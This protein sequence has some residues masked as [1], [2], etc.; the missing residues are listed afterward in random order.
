MCICIFSQ[1]EPRTNMYYK[2]TVF[3][4][5]NSSI[6]VEYIMKSVLWSWV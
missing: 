2:F 3:V 5:P 1:F 6:I 4:F